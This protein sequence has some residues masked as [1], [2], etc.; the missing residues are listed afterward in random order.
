MYRTSPPSR[1]VARAACQSASVPCREGLNSEANNFIFDRILRPACTQ[2]DV[3]EQSVAPIVDDVMLG[4]NG[5]VMAYGQTGAGKTYTLAS[6]ETDNVGMTPRALADI[7]NKAAVDV[8]HSYKVFISYVQ[9]Y[10]EVIK[11]LLLPSAEQLAIREDANGVFLSNVH[12]EEVRFHT[13]SAQQLAIL[14]DANDAFLSNVSQSPTRVLTPRRAQ[15]RNTQDCLRLLQRGE[16][17]RVFASTEMNA[18]SSRSHAIV[19]VTVFKQRKRST[20]RIENGR[21]VNVRCALALL[22]VCC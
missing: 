15:V 19:I 20:T 5:S 10:M 6:M 2:Q 16:Q 9:I 17:N 8:V 7:F 12:E 4:Y 3:Y 21:E 11:D 18:H 14:E 1:H 13:Q 22:F